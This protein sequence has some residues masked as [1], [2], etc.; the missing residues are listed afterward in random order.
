MVSRTPLSDVIK[1]K[2]NLKTTGSGKV[3]N[4]IN[5]IKIARDNELKGM[6]QP[7]KKVSGRD[8]GNLKRALS[9]ASE[10]EGQTDRPWK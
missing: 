5:K 2:K 3:I 4:K 7:D 9:A 6:I 1:W 8:Q 10:E